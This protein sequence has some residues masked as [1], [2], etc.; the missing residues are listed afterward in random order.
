MKIHDFLHAMN[1]RVMESQGIQTTS[2][3]S[4]LN[5]AIK[6]NA[7]IEI[8]ERL[9]SPFKS[10][11]VLSITQCHISRKSLQTLQVSCKIAMIYVNRF[12]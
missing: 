12:H 5:Q 11:A 4:F 2:K 7:D 3:K 8:T 9:A 10:L 6:L 1:D